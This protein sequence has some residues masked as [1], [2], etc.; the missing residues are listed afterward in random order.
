[1]HCLRN[2]KAQDTDAI[3]SV[4]VTPCSY[5][6]IYRLNHPNFQLNPK[7]D[8]GLQV[9]P[10]KNYGKSLQMSYNVCEISVPMPF[11]VILK[12]TIMYNGPL[13]V[14]KNPV[15]IIARAIPILTRGSRC[16]AI[17][18]WFLKGCSRNY[19]YS[20]TKSWRVLIS[21]CASSVRPWI[22]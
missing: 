20:K 5:I 10:H 16:A 6:V 4:T 18:L 17:M 15:S 3:P 14:N 7:H 19:I 9:W 12:G 22:C 21:I 8:L 1:M 11:L 2:S 13:L